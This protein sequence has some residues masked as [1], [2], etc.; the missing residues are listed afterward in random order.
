M[1]LA[2]AEAAVEPTK[3]F[4]DVDILVKNLGVYAPKSFD[5]IT[6]A[7]GRAIKEAC[8]AEAARVQ[9]FSYLLC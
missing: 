8:L 6:D 2:T 4:P 7:D 5:E 3:W 1:N 9:P